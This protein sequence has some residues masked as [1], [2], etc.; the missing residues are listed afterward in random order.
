MQ[1]DDKPVTDAEIE[2]EIRQGRR[3]TPEEALGRMA[4][5]GAMKGASAVSPQQQAENEIST[6]L[7]SNLVDPSGALKVVL[8]RHL[9]GSRLLLQALDRPLAAISTFC[10]QVLASDNRLSEIVG[11]ADIE[12]GRSM[13]ERPHFEREG[14]PPDRDDPYTLESVRRALSAI[15]DRCP[16]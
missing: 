5:P 4:G 9:N 13:D 10:G 11:E 15:L 3:F 12:W 6:W 14:A 2:R 16:S 8:C 7:S 1:G